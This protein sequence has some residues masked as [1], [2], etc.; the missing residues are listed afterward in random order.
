MY[1]AIVE[2]VS[3]LI[4]E[5]KNELANLSNVSSLLN[6]H[7]EGINWVGFY[8]WYDSE[9]TLILG[10]FQGKP[11]CIRIAM[12]RG[13]CGTAAESRKPAVVTDVFAF[14]GHIACDPA[15][16]SE[17]VVPIVADDR[18]IGVLDIDAPTTGRFD[19]E[20]AIGLQRVVDVLVAGTVFTVR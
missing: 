17:V 8:L 6:L 4:H 1:D 3:H 12:G 15:S 11:A 16:R 7:L 5:E 2:Q 14:P 18:L 13:V 19:D 10:P 20:D 9:N